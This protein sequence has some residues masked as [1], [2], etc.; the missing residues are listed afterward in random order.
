MQQPAAELVGSNP[1]KSSLRIVELLLAAGYRPT[2]WCNVAP[3]PFINRGREVLQV[4]DP[5][6]VR[7]PALSPRQGMPSDVHAWLLQEGGS[8]G[9]RMQHCSSSFLPNAAG[10]C[11]WRAAAPGAPP[12]TVTGQTPSRP[13]SAPFC[14]HATGSA[15]AR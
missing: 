11:L 7:K 1:K 3:P 14:W 15:L 9:T 2:V 13:L 6:D 12:P 5:L 4:F 8:R 10:C